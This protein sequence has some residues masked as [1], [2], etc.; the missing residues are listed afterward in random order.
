MSSLDENDPAVSAYVERV[1]AFQAQQR[2]LVSHQALISQTTSYLWDHCVLAPH[3]ATNGTGKPIQFT[4]SLTKVQS[5]C[6]ESAL[7]RQEESL[8]IVKRFIS[9]NMRKAGKE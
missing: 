8:E 5:N 1:Q 4:G 7:K 6:I 3:Q 2:D 9:E